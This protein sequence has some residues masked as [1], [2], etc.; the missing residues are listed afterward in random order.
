MVKSKTPI[1]GDLAP[2]FSLQSTSGKS[3]SLADLAGRKVVLYFYPKDDTPGCTVEACSFR[4]EH[5][6]LQK[7]GVVVLGVSRDTLTSHDKF[8]AKYELPFDLLSDPENALAKRYGAFGKKMMYGREVEGTI[9]STFLIDERGKLIAKWSPVKVAGH[10][11]QVLAALGA[12]MAAAPGPR[13]AQK[14]TAA[15]K[16]AAKKA[17]SKKAASKKAASKK[18]A[19]KKAAS[20]RTASK[21]PAR[22]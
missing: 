1:V 22:A 21:R 16:T 5:S 20:K 3:V 8:R 13:A 15:K 11:S 17:A 19:S 7:A 2:A 18:A 12:S 10:T 14:K 9:R 4:D 6:V